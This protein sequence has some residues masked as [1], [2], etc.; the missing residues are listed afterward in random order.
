MQNAHRQARN[1][2]QVLIVVI[3]IMVGLAQVLFAET[4]TDLRDLPTTYQSVWSWALLVG[5]VL[6][7]AGILIK[8]A[9]W[10]LLTELAGMLSL[11][12]A[13]AA[14]AVAIIAST[15]QAASLVSTP[16]MLA[17]SIA[18]FV[19]CGRIIKKT[20]RHGRTERLA[21]EVSKQLGEQLTEHLQ[22]DLTTRPPED[23]EP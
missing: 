4:P 23:E 15:A 21:D 22:V 10:G 7:M 8:D 14:Y 11:G 9:Y 19:R 2:F 12:F 20:T 13:T 18:S 6:A 16:I 17:F 5:G 3:C 1:E